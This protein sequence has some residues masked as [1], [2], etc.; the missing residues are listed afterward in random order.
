MIK[1]RVHEINQTSSGGSYVCIFDAEV[2]LRSTGKVEV[3][4]AG[5]E[6]EDAEA[7]LVCLA[8]EAIRAGVSQVIE[9]MGRGASIL[10]T[11]LVVHPVDFKESRF[12][13]FAAREMQRLLSR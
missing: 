1:V 11:R 6:P 13:L 12:K 2:M 3:V 7:E 10:V 9:P 4:V 5:V 8:G